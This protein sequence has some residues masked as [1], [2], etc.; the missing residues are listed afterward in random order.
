M[1]RAFIVAIV[2]SIVFVTSAVAQGSPEGIQATGIGV[3]SAPAQTAHLQILLGSSAAFGMGSIEMIEMP[4]GTPGTDSAQAGPVNMIGVSEDQLGPVIDVIAG[5]GIAEDAITVTVPSS[6]K[7]FG[8]GGP[9]TA[10]IRVSIEQPSGEDL[11]AL[12]A[13]IHAAAT[14]GGLTVLHVGA[15]Y[16]AADCAALTQQAREAAIAGANQRAQG[17]AQG[18]GVTLGE[19]ALASE[20]PYFGLTGAESC[21]PAGVVASFGSDGPGTDPTFDPNAIE[22]RVT[23]QVTLTYAFEAAA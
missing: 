8:V 12:V 3:A 17:L 1:F 19:L 16:D 22:A 9:E 20:T 5:A 14:D 4:A 15:R 18:L 2:W 13:A 6:N 10:E 23:I 21:T 11:I 7:L